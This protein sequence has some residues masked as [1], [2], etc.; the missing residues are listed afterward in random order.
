MMQ[1]WTTAADIR[2]QLVALW[3]R[4]RLL[5]AGMNGTPLFPYRLR[6]RKP[7][8]KELGGRF[9]DVR[10]WIKALEEGS[11]AKRGFGYEIAWQEG[12]H[13][14]LGRN[15]VPSSVSVCSETDALRLIGKERDAAKFREIVAMTVGEFSQL[16]P[17]LARYP[18]VALERREDWER[19]LAVL[20][21]FRDHLRCGLY[22]RQ[23]NIEGVDT[24]FFED[25]RGV[26]GELLDLVLPSE[27]IS[28]GLGGARNFE[29]RYGLRWKPPLVRFRVLDER[30]R[31]NGLSDMTVPAS[32]FAQLR[33]AVNRVFVTENEI[34]G[35]AF[36][37]M[38][39]SLVVFGLGYGLELLQASEWM[40]TKTM[41]YWGDID[42]HGFAMLDRLRS[43]F[44]DA[45]SFLMDKS[46]LL[47]H[48]ALWGQERERFD[49]RL[50]R[51][52]AEES[53]LF[54]DL[55]QDRV[56]DRVRLE[57]ERIAFP[58]VE[59]ALLQVT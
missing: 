38:S 54:D 33:L 37:T 10:L 22:L 18:L 53:A 49:N 44:P 57:Q 3:N 14:Q 29:A 27:S 4:G 39:D 13:R 52:N 42:T 47:A 1:T 34:N 11:N 28:A 41:Y 32:E 17:W 59:R 25:R 9:E 48:R 15:R 30:L 31:V 51:L 58:Y 7:S 21:W 56:G 50:T 5:A 36:P 8:A 46:T 16:E 12:Q 19:I 24:K 40:K 35:L 2:E 43:A 6:F 26:L 55:Q 20:R 23:L 45:R